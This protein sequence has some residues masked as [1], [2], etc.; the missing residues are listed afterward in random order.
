M[1]SASHPGTM[2]RRHLIV[3]GGSVLVALA[4][5]CT[6]AP[7]G[8][9]DDGDDGDDGYVRNRDQPDNE[10][11]GTLEDGDLTFR[12]DK[13]I[14]NQ[15]NFHLSYVTGFVQNEGDATGDRVEVTAEFLDENGETVGSNT[16]GVGSIDPGEVD[17]FEINVPTELSPEDVD[18]YQLSATDAE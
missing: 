14:E 11:S 13:F 16:Q 9:G 10:S 3:S 6:T 15:D 12:D 2:Q 17:V 5:G 8:G 4:A 1:V 7:D 18:D